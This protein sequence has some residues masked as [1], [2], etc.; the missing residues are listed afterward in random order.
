MEFSLFLKAEVYCVLKSEHYNVLAHTVLALPHR[1]RRS[2][3]ST[4]AVASCSAPA[5]V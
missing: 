3:R 1:F 4:G 5:E 2:P